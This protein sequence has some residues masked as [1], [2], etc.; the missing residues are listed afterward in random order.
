MKTAWA[1]H[2]AGGCGVRRRRFILFCLRA[3]AQRRTY[4]LHTLYY[5]LLH[6]AFPL[7]MGRLTI[8]DINA[9]CC[10]LELMA[11]ILL[12]VEQVLGTNVARMAAF[13]LPSAAITPLLRVALPYHCHRFPLRASCGGC[14]FSVRCALPCRGTLLCCGRPVPHICLVRAILRVLRF[15][16]V[17][18]RLYLHPTTPFTTAAPCLLPASPLLAACAR[19]WPL[20]RSRPAGLLPGRWAGKPPRCLLAVRLVPTYWDA[21]V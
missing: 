5:L 3:S 4:L 17:L 2:F 16:C 9:R 13:V 6:Q 1:Q 7:R 14:R 19:G 20:R 21:A 11:T 18:W 12:T 10:V 8:A 15:A